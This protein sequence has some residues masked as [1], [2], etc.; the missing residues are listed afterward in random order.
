MTDSISMKEIEEM[1]KLQEL[2]LQPQYADAGGEKPEEKFLEQL[3][4]KPI[5]EEIE[6]KLRGKRWNSLK[7]EWEDIA[8]IPDNKKITEEGIGWIMTRVESVVNTNSIYSNLDDEDIRK[9]VIH[10]GDE[11]T[12]GLS[13]NY[14]KFNMSLLD[15]NRI[16]HL[17]VD[18]AFISLKRGGD[19]LTLRMLRTMI[20]SKELTTH[21]MKSQ[22]ENKS[23]F[24]KLMGK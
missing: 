7:Q 18:M 10:L 17:C 12:M 14:K 8:K 24:S 5:N 16:P 15:V 4:P 23:I 2:G 19:A 13:L 20:Q 3:N 9:I 11:L 21:G 22:P 1:Q 6:Y